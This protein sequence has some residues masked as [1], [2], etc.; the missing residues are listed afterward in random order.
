MDALVDDNELLS[1]ENDV[2]QESTNESLS[3]LSEN[4]FNE[5]S[6]NDSNASLDAC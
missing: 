5:N 3:Q 4:S 1:M 2:F 6:C